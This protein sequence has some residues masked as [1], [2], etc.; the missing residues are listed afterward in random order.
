MLVYLGLLVILVPALGNHGLFLSISLFMVVRALTL[1]YYYPRI[2]NAMDYK[3][4][5]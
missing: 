5:D 4:S 1:G 2:V 3:K